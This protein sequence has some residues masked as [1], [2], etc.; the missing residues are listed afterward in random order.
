VRLRREAPHTLAGAYALEALTEPDRLRFK[1]HLAECDVCRLEAASLREAAA[2]LAAPVAE[3][4][5][6]DLRDRLLAA[7]ATIRQQPPAIADAAAGL[8]RRAS[9]LVAPRMAV[10][11]AGGCMLVALA[12]GG[13]LI[14]SQHRL[15]QEQL[16]SREV[17]AVL[18]A[19]DAKIITD[20]AFTAGSATVVM[21]HRDRALVLTTARLPALPAGQHYQVWLMGHD[22]PRSAGMLPDPRRGMTAPVV[23]TG[24]GP[25]EMVGVTVEPG[26]GTVS[27]T[28]APVLML[29]LPA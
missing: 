1:S 16:R 13:M 2:R 9:R 10:A 20:E 12:L 29:V 18:N 8:G 23:V 3:A 11:I 17:A 25:G 28:S 4:P 15:S 21:S 22:R 6:A 27:P 24:V 5:P 7:V 19:P 26:N 14:S